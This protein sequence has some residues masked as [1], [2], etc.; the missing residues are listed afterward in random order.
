MLVVSA[1]VAE[2]ADPPDPDWYGPVVVMPDVTRP[3]GTGELGAVRAPEPPLLACGC[4]LEVDVVS[5]CGLM[6]VRGEEGDIPLA[7]R[8]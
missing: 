7:K 1:A 3:R 8:S 5:A 6:G 2:D 4:A